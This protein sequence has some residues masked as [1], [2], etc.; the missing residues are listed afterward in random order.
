[1]IGLLAVIDTDFVPTRRNSNLLKARIDTFKAHGA[2]IEP[3]YSNNVTHVL[4]DCNWDV[5]KALK[6]LGMNKIQGNGVMLSDDWPSACIENNKLVNS[7]SP[8]YQVKQTSAA[9]KEKSNSDVEIESSCAKPEVKSNAASSAEPEVQSEAKEEIKSKNGD[10]LDEIIGQ[11]IIHDQAS[12]LLSDEDVDESDSEGDH[13]PGPKLK[14]DWYNFLCMRT[15]D[16]GSGP[17]PNESII[18]VFSLMLKHYE[19]IKDEFRSQAYRKA[20]N[21]LKRTNRPITT[22]A[23]A[24]KLAGFGPH[25]SEKLE[26]VVNTGDLQKLKYARAQGTGR[27]LGMLQKIYGVGPKTSLKWFRQG[28]RTLDDV[29]RRKDLTENQTVS[30]DHYDDFAERIS[31]TEVSQHFEMVKEAVAE[32]DP[33]VQATCMGSYRRGQADCGDID[34]ILTKPGAGGDELCDL[35][36]ELLEKLFQEGFAKYTFGGREAWSKRWLGATTLANGKWR[37]MDILLVPWNERAGA[38][39]YYT[40][41]DIFNRSL[42]LLA[43]KKGYRLN[44]KG[45]FIAPGRKDHNAVGPL[46]EGEDEKRIFEILNV[47]YR[48]PTERNIG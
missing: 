37:R 32:I 9:V 48:L 29:A 22:A 25:L 23:Q 21:T 19:N 14:G 5:A 44:E 18:T 8:R 42:R 15:K 4:V 34:I 13:S 11:N 39:I 46:V 30:L 45:L 27:V 16:S 7:K 38:F 10:E 31:R 1:M 40:G 3:E 35:L 41:N 47:P 6:Y 20:I 36:Y 2:Q 26:E 17:N 24:R 33:L 43:Q 12:H 28:V